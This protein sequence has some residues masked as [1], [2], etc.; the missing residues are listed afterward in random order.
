ME[1]NH[2]DNNIDWYTSNIIHLQWDSVYFMVSHIFVRGMRSCLTHNTLGNGS[3]QRTSNKKSTCHF[4]RFTARRSKVHCCMRGWKKD[5]KTASIF[6]CFTFA[7]KFV[8][9]L[10]WTAEQTDWIDTCEVF[11]KYKSIWRNLINFTTLWK[12]KQNEIS[13][14]SM[15]FS[16]R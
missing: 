11:R 13:I 8:S 16:M 10:I 14:F 15:N 6:V 5:K 9:W 2:I 12:R 1:E 4:K 3:S 7:L